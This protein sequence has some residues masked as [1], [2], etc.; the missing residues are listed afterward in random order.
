MDL[1]S[2]KRKDLVKE[3][4]KAG[5][6]SDEVLN[7]IGSVKREIFVN[8]ELRRF[9]YD[10]TSLP[11]ISGQ[12]ISQ[13][14]TVAFMTEL[15]KIRPGDKVL[16]IGTGSGYQSAVLKELG[17]EVYSVERIY[18]LYRS[19]KEKLEAAGY[20]VF[21]KCDDGTMGWENHAPY[22]KIIVTAGSP[23]I[24][25]HLLEQLTFGGLMVIPVGDEAS[26]D[27][28]LVKK[29]IDE[30][31]NSGNENSETDE[32]EFKVKPKYKMKRFKN[33]KFVPL[34]GEEAWQIGS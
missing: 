21:L 15:L 24:P 5:I 12:T 34:I 14:Y 7:A 4:K 2:I 16:E 26:Q 23:K 31:E 25:A 29:E 6:V 11:I 9:A 19:A 32:A 28:I 18:E 13:P 27:L 17:A 8:E 1:N 20:E 30:T 33:F 10:N 22:D 3:I